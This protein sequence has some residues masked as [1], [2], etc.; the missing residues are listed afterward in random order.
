MHPA[1]WL[2]STA[3]SSAAWIS[4]APLGLAFG[5]P[6]FALAA[7]IVRV[8]DR[9]PFLFLQERIGLHG[10]AFT[11]YKLR[12]LPVIDARASIQAER[13]VHKPTYDTTRT[14]RFWRVTSIDEI[15]QF[16]NVLK[17]EMSLIGHRPFPVYYL[18]HLHRLEGYDQNKVNQYLR[19]IYQYKPGMSSLSSVNGRGDLSMQEKFEYDL[20]YAQRAGFFY[21]LKLLVQT[22][23]VVLTRK[24]A[25]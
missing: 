16:W 23:Y 21:D 2:T 4:W 13:I 6:V 22:L 14:G 3:V 1:R 8:V 25:K 10:Q 24:G 7:I 20:I 18:P 11:M 9:A 12:T 19:V 17:G 15:I 5:M